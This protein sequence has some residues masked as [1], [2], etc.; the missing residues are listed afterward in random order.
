L[1]T[2]PLAPLLDHAV[3]NAEADKAVA[4]FFHEGA[5]HN[6]TRAYQTGL[7]YWGAWHVLRFGRAIEGPVAAEAVLQ[8]IVDHLEHNPTLADPEVTPYANREQTTQHLLPLAIDRLL[9]ERT[10]KAKL[11]PWTFATVQARLSA[12]SR[13]HVQYLSSNPHLGLGPAT[14]PIRDPRV[15]QLM[16]AVRRAYIRRGRGQRQPAAAT[17][18]VI[19]ALV[20]SCG[21]D[22]EGIRDRALLLF[23]FSSGGR[24]RS[25][26]VA[27]TF[28]NLRR[29]GE[30]FIFDLA[31]SKTNQSGRRDPNNLKPVQGAAAEALQRWLDMLFKQRITEGPIFRHIA[32]DRRIGE[33]MKGATV[34]DIV[35]RRAKLTN[36][37]LG[38]LSA[39]SLRSGFVTEA[40]KQGVSLPETMALTGHRS[41]PTV[42]RYF[43]AGDVSTLKGARLMEDGKK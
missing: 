10:Y 23:G 17:K 22:L 13:A 37:S 8:F 38:R 5:S 25:E 43:Q 2:E 27:L 33:P 11:G 21:D 9:V 20:A 34:R 4:A 26:I 19:E 28:E 14:N 40:A 3:L 32:K 16:Q 1:C 29:D 31:W 36:Q 41:V 30:G 18:S 39:H 15:R 7:R 42:L 6:T 24:R 35:L 12:L